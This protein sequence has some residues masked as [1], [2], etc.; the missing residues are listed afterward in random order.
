MEMF[1]IV[2]QVFLSLQ[3]KEK[4]ICTAN[5]SLTCQIKMFRIMLFM[6]SSQQ[7]ICTL[8]GSGVLHFHWK[9]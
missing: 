9:R 8:K 1:L 7:V 6:E 2:K 4:K 5:I 3:M